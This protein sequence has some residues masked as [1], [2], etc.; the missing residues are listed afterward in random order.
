MHSVVAEIVHGVH[1]ALPHTR[2]AECEHNFLILL[3]LR[4]SGQTVYQ[5]HRRRHRRH[6]R[7][8]RI[9]HVVYRRL[10]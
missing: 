6:R 2:W 5:V 9:R 4:G 7:R 3:R 1:T 10:V 8:R